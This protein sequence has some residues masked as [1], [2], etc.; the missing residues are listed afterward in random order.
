MG[1]AL[2]RAFV[3]LGDRVCFGSREPARVAETCRAEGIAA[4]TGAP[5]DAAAFGDVIVLATVWQ[6]TAARVHAA[7]SLDGKII[8]SCVN[9]TSQSEG[10]D[11]ERLEIGHST[12]AA[13]QIA[14]WAPGARVVE[15][16]NATYA[17]A[18]DMAPQPLRETVLYCGDDREACGLAAAIIERFG[19][20][21]LDAGPLR[22]AR[23]LEPLSALVVHLV[24]NAGYGPL[25]I[26]QQW[27]RSADLPRWRGEVPRANF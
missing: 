24:R 22:N 4:M 25:G 18:I 7:G 14:A 26:R 2:G 23:Y 20:D 19:F 9:P 8:L 5:R 16:F 15:T 6:E 11:G 17:E 27:R 12:S 10:S 13:E 21:P 3:R 1:Y